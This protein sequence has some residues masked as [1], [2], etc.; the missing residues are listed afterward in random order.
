MKQFMKENTPI[1]I[2]LGLQIIFLTLKLTGVIHWIW[3]LVLTPLLVLASVIVGTALAGLLAGIT[4]AIKD[5]HKSKLYRINKLPKPIVNG[6]L[7]GY[8]E[9]EFEEFPDRKD[10]N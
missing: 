6:F 3:Y 7:K 10:L 1:V 4:F 5:Y 9:N 8:L 2:L